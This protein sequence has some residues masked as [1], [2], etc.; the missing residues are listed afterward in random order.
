MKKKFHHNDSLSK[1]IDEF[2]R[3]QEEFK[4]KINSDNKD[5]EKFFC[6]CKMFNK[7]RKRLE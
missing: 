5:A 1:E 2:L 7:K 6:G 3:E 4:F